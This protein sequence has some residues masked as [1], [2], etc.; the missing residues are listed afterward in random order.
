MTYGF[1]IGELIRRVDGR[2]PRE[3]F[4]RGNRCEDGRRLPVGVTSEADIARMATLAIPMGAFSA[5]GVAPETPDLHRPDRCLDGP[6]RPAESWW[7]R[8]DPAAVGSGTAARWPGSARSSRAGARLTACAS[9]RRRSSPKRAREPGFAQ[10]PYLGW[11]G[12]ALDPPSTAKSSRL[13]RPRPRTGAA[14]AVRGRAWTRK[15]GVRRRLRAKQL[16]HPPS[17]GDAARHGRSDLRLRRIMHAMTAVL[18]D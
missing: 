13:R 11:L 3:F 10:C 18:R 12:S 16:D 4:L 5:E 15:P 7:A 17:G 6:L 8:E 2:G 14:R 1:L 9:S